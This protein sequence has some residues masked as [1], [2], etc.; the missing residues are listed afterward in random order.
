MTQ[1]FRGARHIAIE[2]DLSNISLTDHHQSLAGYE[3][4]IP[5]PGA[6]KPEFERHA[7][8]LRGLGIESEILQYGRLDD[9]RRRTT[10]RR[11]FQQKGL[12]PTTTIAVFP[13]AQHDVRV[14]H[15]GYGEALKGLKDFQ[16]S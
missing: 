6:H 16:I 5:T 1:L 8:F 9:T 14:W 3:Q 11:I 13:G 15:L 4:L 12:S 7:D 10:G 2:G